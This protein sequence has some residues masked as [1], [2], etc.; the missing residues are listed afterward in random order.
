M[1]VDETQIM[2]VLVNIISNAV[3]SI[4][5]TDRSGYICL[6][7][8]KENNTVK[9]SVEDNGAGVAEEVKEKL[10]KDAN[11]TF[12]KKVNTNFGRQTFLVEAVVYDNAEAK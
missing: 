5:T 10:G 1:L 3:D 2:Q 8:E 12:I 9:I 6:V 11:L 7:V 4:L